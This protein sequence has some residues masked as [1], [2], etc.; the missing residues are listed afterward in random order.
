MGRGAGLERVKGSASEQKDLNGQRIP[1]CKE[2]GWWYSGESGG[3][4]GA[5]H[6]IL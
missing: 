3:Q 2:S 5:G 6:E 4:G 1:E